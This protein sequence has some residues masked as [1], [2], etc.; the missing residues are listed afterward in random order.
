MSSGDLLEIDPLELKFPCKFH[1]HAL[2]LVVCVV[3]IRGISFGSM[4]IIPVLFV[5]F[6]F[7]FGF[8]SRIE[9]ADLVLHASD[10]QVG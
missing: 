5:E 1:V 6:L 2:C 9:E 4:A 3:V 10:E 8:G 7:D